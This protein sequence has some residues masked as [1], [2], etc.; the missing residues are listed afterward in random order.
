MRS[1]AKQDTEEGKKKKLKDIAVEN[2][3]MFK[4]RDELIIISLFTD[5]ETC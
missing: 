5:K 2:L 4:S 3:K 1:Q